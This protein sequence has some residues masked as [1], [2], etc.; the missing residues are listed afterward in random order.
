MISRKYAQTNLQHVEYKFGAEDLERTRLINYAMIANDVY[1]PEK[2]TTVPPGWYRFEHSGELEYG[3]ACAYYVNHP[4]DPSKFIMAMRGT[5]NFSNVWDDLKLIFDIVPRQFYSI[6]DWVDGATHRLYLRFKRKIKIIDKDGQ[7]EIKD[8]DELDFLNRVDVEA[9]VGHSLGAVLSDLCAQGWRPSITFENPGSYQ[10]LEALYK[11]QYGD[12]YRIPLEP[13]IQAMQHMCE[14]YQSHPNLINSLKT[15]IGHLY[16]LVDKPYS[17]KN[18]KIEGTIPDYS[19][20]NSAIHDPYY[21]SLDYTM[22]QHGMD[23]ILHYLQMGGRIIVD[24]QNSRWTEGYIDYTNVDKNKDYWVGFFKAM[25]DLKIY[26][27][28]ESTYE[29]HLAHGLMM[30]HNVHQGLLGAN[31]VKEDFIEPSAPIE[32]EIIEDYVDVVASTKKALSTV[33][34]FGNRASKPIPVLMSDPYAPHVQDVK[35]EPKSRCVI[36]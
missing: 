33:G 8:E 29:R 9:A 18:I 10:A 12:H 4:T 34:M 2:P 26:S 32:L 14:S 23:G 27:H 1:Y 20:G 21:S 35:P 7:V 11:I 17:Y 28:P 36:L 22:D 15:K 19:L 31:E 24:T 3:A 25:W 6:T 5:D 30:V 13:R 16:R